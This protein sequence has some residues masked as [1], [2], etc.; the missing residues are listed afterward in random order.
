[1]EPMKAM[2]SKGKKRRAR[3]GAAA[4]LLRAMPCTGGCPFPEDPDLDARDACPAWRIGARPVVA[5]VPH[6]DPAAHPLDLWAIPG[7]KTLIHDGERLWLYGHVGRELVTLTLAADVANGAP[8]AYAVP[9][10]VDP[11]RY[12]FTL[13]TALSLL[14]GSDAHTP[15]ALARPPRSALTHMRALQ[16]LDGVAA[17]ASQREI[18]AVL[19]GEDEVAARWSPDGELRAQVRYLIQRGRALVEGDYRTLL[20]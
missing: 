2:E 4:A 14:Q 18:A 12:R 3:P 15:T 7:R 11:A 5:L 17:G 9:A 1:M 20:V 16:A 19:F 8:F 13:E 10:G 6:T